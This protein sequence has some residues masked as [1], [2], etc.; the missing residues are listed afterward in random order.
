MGIHEVVLREIYGNA[1]T[2][3]PAIAGDAE[4][5]TGTCQPPIS[6]VLNSRGGAH[7]SGIAGTPSGQLS[8]LLDFR[9]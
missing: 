5:V 7:P 1:R 8:V 9:R 2:G 4:P 6:T 3:G